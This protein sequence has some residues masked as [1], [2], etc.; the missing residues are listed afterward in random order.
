MAVVNGSGQWLAKGV[1]SV[2]WAAL[3]N[4]DTGSPSYEA[5]L[6]IKEVSVTGTFGS[7]GSVS[8]E[9]SNDDTNWFALSDPQGN[10]ITITAAGMKRIQDNP[11][12]IRPHVTAGDGTTAISVVLISRGDR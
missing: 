5:T 2:S 9:G 1:H 8:I 11:K 6:P 10:A 4:G 3:A 7:A 12:A